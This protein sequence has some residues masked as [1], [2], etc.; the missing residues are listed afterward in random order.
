MY[1]ITYDHYILYDPR[2]A[3]AEDKLMITEPDVYLAVGKAG[4]CPLSSSRT[5]P[6][7]TG[8]SGCRAWSPCW[9]TGP[10]L[11]GPHHQGQRHLLRQPQD[12]HGGP[13]GLPQ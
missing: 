12:H 4:K 8:S 3:T 7:W 10:G 6:I 5:T 1:Q 2:F 9:T 11:P 13:Y